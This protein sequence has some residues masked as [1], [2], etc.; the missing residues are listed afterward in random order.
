MALNGSTLYIGGSFS[1][2][3][4]VSG[5]TVVCNNIAAI[6][7][8]S[9]AIEPWHPTITGGTTTP[10][11]NAITITANTVYV[12]GIFATVG[13]TPVAR[14]NLAAIN[15]Y[16]SGLTAGQATSWNPTPDDVV[17][18]IYS[19]G[20]T[21]Y[22]GGDF[23]H[24]VS[25]ARN[26]VAAVNVGGTL[27]T[28][29]PG[30]GATITHV[31]SIAPVS[32]GL[33][34]GG[35]FSSLG[36]Q[37]R[38][39]AAIIPSTVPTATSWDANVAGPVFKVGSNG[40]QAFLA[41]SFATVHSATRNN[42]AAVKLFD[43]TVQSFDPEPDGPVYGMSVDSTQIFM[44]GAFSNE[45]GQARVGFGAGN[46]TFSTATPWTSDAGGGASTGYTMLETPW[47]I[48]IGGDFTTIN[49]VSQKGFAGTVP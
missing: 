36:G 19:N 22:V 44:A 34:I 31:Y 15:G 8:I 47:A 21:V 39:N 35:D 16:N 43:G 11:V 48:F 12:G 17:R 40:T 18:T 29:N 14:Q 28:W 24:I 3:I 41:G 1:H 45:G 10:V 38:N 26:M 4:P 30:S 25:A 32:A 37:L 6:D 49:G 27:T 5:P 46:L 13:T 2:L 9:G 33:L 20:T 42:F 23:T 7:A